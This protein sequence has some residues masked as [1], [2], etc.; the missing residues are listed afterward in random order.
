MAIV[1]DMQAPGEHFDYDLAVYT[2]SLCAS[3]LPY[4]YGWPSW[5]GYDSWWEARRWSPP[6]SS[7]RWAGSDSAVR[8]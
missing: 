1:N 2:V 3:P 6:G 8:R 7:C 4:P 5:W